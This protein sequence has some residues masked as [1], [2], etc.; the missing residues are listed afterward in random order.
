MTGKVRLLE[1]WTSWLA[2]V[3]ELYNLAAS[4]IRARGLNAEVLVPRKGDEVT[5]RVRSFTGVGSVGALES[6]DRCVDASRGVGPG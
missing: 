2:D 3:E 4:Q 1:F 6:P 5:F